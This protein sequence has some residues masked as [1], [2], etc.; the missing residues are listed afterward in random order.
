MTSEKAPPPPAV[1]LWSLPI[2]DGSA[3]ARK[4]CVSGAA[5]RSRAR[6]TGPSDP[7]G[8]LHRHLAGVHQLP[9]READLPF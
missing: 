7:L 9:Q 8:S 2:V 1:W 6:V 4:G 3:R 5:A